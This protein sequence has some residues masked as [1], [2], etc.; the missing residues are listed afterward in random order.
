M[1]YIPK[2]FAKNIL[3]IL[4]KKYFGKNR[5]PGETLFFPNRAAGEALFKI[6]SLQQPYFKNKVTPEALFGF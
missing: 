4:D 5:V 1:G 3:K 2:L 6:G